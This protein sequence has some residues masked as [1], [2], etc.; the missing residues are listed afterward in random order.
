MKQ[1]LYGLAV[2]IN[3][4][5]P[6]LYNN[7]NTATRNNINLKLIRSSGINQSLVQPQAYICIC[8]YKHNCEL[9]CSSE[10]CSI[11]FIVRAIILI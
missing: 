4:I 7:V 6:N 2:K 10:E 5:T 9:S 1:L 8:I 11:D 3:E